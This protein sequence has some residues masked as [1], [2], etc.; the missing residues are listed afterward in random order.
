VNIDTVR[1]SHILEANSLYDLNYFFAHTAFVIAHKNESFETL[2]SVIWYLPI[3]SPILIVTNCSEI[4]KEELKQGLAK[5]LAHS[6]QIYL[7][8][9]KDEMIARFFAEHG[10]HAILAA[11]G[12]VVNGKGEG[13]YIGALIATLLKSPRWI[14]FYD[15]DNFV[16]NALL[17][18]TLAMSKLFMQEYMAGMQ[19]NQEVEKV[20]HLQNVRICWA[21]KPSITSGSI[22][23]GIL[24]RC[25]RVVSPLMTTV[26]EEWFGVRDQTIITSNAGEQGFTMETVQTLRFSSGYSVETFQLLDL[27]SKALPTGIQTPADKVVL[28]QYQAQ[29]PHFHEKRDD[30]HIK[31]MIADSLGGFY[32]FQDMLTLAIRRQLQRVYHEMDL[33]IRRPDVYPA[34]QDLSLEASDLYVNNYRLLEPYPL[35][36]EEEEAMCG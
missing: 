15:A 33:E 19:E 29:S 16:P 36:N 7:I 6:R 25:T 11:D 35:I 13:M 5:Q 27:L 23:A 28:Q 21:S 32:Y 4:E 26:I 30:E 22:A 1:F 3:N 18:Y 2:L 8:H 34:L 9:Q 24:G 12:K 17:E 20:R 14:V 10:V 31:R